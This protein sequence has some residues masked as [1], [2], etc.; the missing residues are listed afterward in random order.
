MLT[1][2]IET[3]TKAIEVESRKTK[4]EAAIR[5]KDSSSTT[6]YDGNIR[7]TK[8]LKRSVINLNTSTISFHWFV[9]AILDNKLLMF[10]SSIRV[11]K[12]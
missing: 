3:L 12:T 11:A 2:K 9:Y 1:K 4:R 10:S 8:S 5:E 7:Q 6:K